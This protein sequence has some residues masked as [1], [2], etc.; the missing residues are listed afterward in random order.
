MAHAWSWQKYCYAKISSTKSLRMKLTWI[1][2][3]AG[4]QWLQL[5]AMLPWC[6][7]SHPSFI[8]SWVEFLW[9]PSQPRKWR[10]LPAI[11]CTCIS[12]SFLK[13]GNHIDVLIT[14]CLYSH[15][16][17]KGQGSSAAIRFQVIFYINNKCSHF[18]FSVLRKPRQC[19]PGSLYCVY[20]CGVPPVAAWLSCPW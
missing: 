3:L 20:L 2:L 19:G 11:Q 18:N 6:F 16:L 9:L 5:L 12:F 1:T 10:K 15:C 4:W 13:T 7:W 8:H 17:G 14:W